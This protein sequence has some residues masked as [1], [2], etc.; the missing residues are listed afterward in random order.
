MHAHTSQTRVACRYTHTSTQVMK[1][2]YIHTQ[3]SRGL[4]CRQCAQVIEA[5]QMSAFIRKPLILPSMRGGG[6]VM[7]Y[8]VEGGGSYGI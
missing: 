2:A 4:L 8:G 5:T 7:E 3:A 1:S 6:G